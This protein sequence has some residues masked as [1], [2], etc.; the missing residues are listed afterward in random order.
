MCRRYHGAPLVTWLG[1]K[2]GHYRLNEAAVC[3][4]RSSADAER[5]RCR[6]CGSPLLFRS[7]RWP[8]E[9]HVVLA[10]LTDAIDQSPQLHVYY[11]DRVPWLPL[12]PTVP[13]YRTLPSHDDAP[14][15][16]QDD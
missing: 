15:P 5:G 4:Y 9:L 2:H 10:A 16:S 7:S 6:A 8:D 1:V 11:G 12:Q 3:W 14:M 13:C